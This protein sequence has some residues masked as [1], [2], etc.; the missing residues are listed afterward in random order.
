[1]WLGSP[2]KRVRE[3]TDKEKSFLGYSAQQYVKLK[4]RH[5]EQT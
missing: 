2:V 1:M 4:N 3:L 5:T